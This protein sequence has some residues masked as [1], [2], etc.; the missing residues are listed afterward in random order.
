MQGLFGAI[1]S[2]ET[3]IAVVEGGAA[4]FELRKLLKFTQLHANAPDSSLLQDLTQ[5]FEPQETC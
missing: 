1:C 5:I 2:K 3:V 4:I